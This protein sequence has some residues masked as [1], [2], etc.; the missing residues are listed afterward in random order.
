[1]KSTK[2]H[3]PKSDLQRILESKAEWSF[4][5]VPEDELQACLEWEFWREAYDL[6]ESVKVVVTNLRNE[7]SKSGGEVFFKRMN[8][9]SPL[10]VLAC[11][12][13]EIWPLKPFLKESRTVRLKAWSFQRQQEEECEAREK[14]RP[15][16]EWEKLNDF[17]QSLHRFCPPNFLH[18]YCPCNDFLGDQCDCRSFLSEWRKLPS[19]KTIVASNSYTDDSM[20]GCVT[21]A[22][23]IDLVQRDTAIVKEFKQWL[24]Q[25]RNEV[26]PLAGFHTGPSEVG[27][28]E[29]VDKRM[30]LLKGLGAIRLQRI[31]GS[32]DRVLNAF[33]IGNDANYLYEAGG[34]PASNSKS[35]REFVLGAQEFIQG[36]VSEVQPKPSILKRIKFGGG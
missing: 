12:S 5:Q 24:K 15:R 11:Y 33:S 22:I 31:I 10:E 29:K 30:R 3:S 35:W 7:R 13:E 9:R 32:F 19:G 25:L 20:F 16:E 14:N 18:N 17:Q 2:G 6:H 1:M 26:A 21:A 28:S 27:R 36:L 8:A 34:L 23:R 4:Y